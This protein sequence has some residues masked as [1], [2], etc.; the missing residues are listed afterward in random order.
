M[1]LGFL[2]P[3]FLAGLAALG[4][5]LYMHLRDRNENAPI[6]F[7]SLMF[8]LRL[9]IRTSDRRRVTD[10]PLL[11]LR[12]LVIA[13]LVLAFSRPFMGNVADASADQRARVLVLMV[14]R[15][16][17]MG[18]TGTWAA[19]MDSARAIIAGLEP[20]DQVSLV[21]FDEEA[22]VAQDW[23]TDHAAARA[24]LEATVPAAR[25]TRMSSALRAA[26]GLLLSAPPGAPELLVVTDMQ[27]SG[28]GGVAGLELPPGVE[29]RAV[30]V[31]TGATRSNTSIS[32]VEARRVATADRVQLQVQARVTTRELG[33]PRRARLSLTVGGR[34]VGAREATLPASGELMVVF[35]PVPAP[36]GAV[37]G[38]VRIAP[39]AL[40]GDDI[41]HFALGADD[42]LRVVM[43]TPDDLGRDETLYLER[44]LAIGRAPAVR[45]ERRRQGTLDAAALTRA[46]LVLLWDVPPP[47][48]A[49]GAA[50]DEWIRRGG[51]LAVHVGPRLGARKLTALAGATSVDGLADR[52]SSGGSAILG[53]L[54]TDH[55]IFSPFRTTQAALSAPRFWRF[56]RLT[57]TVGT[58]VIARF[59]DGQPAVL[60]R[61]VGEGRVLVLALALDVR[62]GDLPLQPAFL[63]LMRRVALHGAGHEATPLW[64]ST[65]ESWMPRGVRRSP[66][67]VAPDGSLIRPV[68]DSAGAALI[69]ELPGVYAA[70]EERVD[71][72]PRALVAVNVGAAES[73]LV[74][75][76]PR[77]L[78]LGVS[79][80]TDSTAR[81]A[82]VQTAAE[83]EGR[84][85]AWRILLLIVALL[86]VG[87]S[88]I[89]ARGW[90]GR[91]RRAT[92]ELDERSDRSSE[93]KPVL[94]SQ[95]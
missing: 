7:P 72:T 21:L 77:E 76:D 86:L 81:D 42:D 56:A 31:A 51:G 62:D 2:V 60:E 34:E 19:A 71:G 69:L 49:A 38:E 40:A 84:Q 16:M 64:R 80:S 52:R 46:S 44:A 15:S 13:L 5:P 11:L 82:G 89:A 8:L 48:G 41:F 90:R 39:D 57:P 12:A 20:R 79:T 22:T 59:D 70:Y 61:R 65:G 55:P 66:V 73:D 29:L 10:W 26:R 35:E 50:L 28:L 91:A 92:T 27:R 88:V 75:A 30:P 45:I 47:T 54:R 85:G 58:E 36:A 3:A 23:T 74:A 33:A 1:G 78:L 87:E 43:I 9:P 68:A 25:A 14:D 17:S 24:V 18:H 53:E 95:A 67:V 32:A 83:V 94:G 63:P 93:A 4:I 37:S 6:R